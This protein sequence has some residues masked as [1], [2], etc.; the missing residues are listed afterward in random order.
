[1][2]WSDKEKS[3]AKDNLWNT[4]STYFQSKQELCSVYTTGLL[5]LNKIYIQ[6]K[7]IRANVMFDCIL[8]V[9][10]V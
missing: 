10:Y 4:S 9:K 5:R 3:S 6:I 8:K 1:M 7:K 2:V